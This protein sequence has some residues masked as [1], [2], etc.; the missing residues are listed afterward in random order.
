M[1]EE[2]ISD[3]HEKSNTQRSNQKSTN[4][5]VTVDVINKISSSSN[6]NSSSTS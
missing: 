5:K 1:S 6:Q 2:A 3:N 4:D